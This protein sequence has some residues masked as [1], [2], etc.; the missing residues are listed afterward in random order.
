[1]TTQEWKTQRNK[2]AANL[3]LLKMKKRA[4]LAS[5]ADVQNAEAIL[6]G[7]VNYRP[8]AE[9]AVKSEAPSKPEKCPSLQASQP[10][11]IP[12]MPVLEFT[13]LLEELT[14]QKA[15][16]HKEMSIRCNRLKDIPD[17]ESAK[18]LV[19]E[20][21]DL[22]EKRT[23]VAVKINFLKANGRLPE[24]AAPEL[25]VED[26]KLKFMENLPTDKYDLSKLLSTLM[27]NLSKAR[28]RLQQSKDPVKKVE[29]SQKVAK[30]EAEVALVRSRLKAFS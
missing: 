5:P 2:A 27:P 15:G 28:G 4:G 13:R 14:L 25:T 10:V 21:D 23:A 17:H 16:F 18:E 29:Y 3:E 7:L 6:Q 26:M 8:E 9:P 19:D 20:I 30:L 12:A 22:Y 1:M 11:D 24:E